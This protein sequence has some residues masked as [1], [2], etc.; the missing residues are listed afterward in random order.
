MN[1]LTNRIPLT[2][3]RIK[4]AMLSG[5]QEPETNPSKLYRMAMRPTKSPYD[6]KKEKKRRKIAK[7]S[8]R[9]NRK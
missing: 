6:F 7:A 1:N 9:R 4:A 3:K 2:R 8:R 5:Y